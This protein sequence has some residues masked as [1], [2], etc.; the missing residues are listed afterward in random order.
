MADPSS[1]LSQ[2]L[3]IRVISPK[4]STD[5]GKESQT[6]SVLYTHP[7]CSRCTDQLPQIYP[8]NISPPPSHILRL[9]RKVP[10]RVSLIT[11]PAFWTIYF[12][13]AM[14]TAVGP[15]II[16]SDLIV[17]RTGHSSEDLN[18][19][20]LASVVEHIRRL[21]SE[22][23][24]RDEQLQAQLDS[25]LQ[26]ERDLAAQDLENHKSI[27]APVRRLPNDVLLRI[28]QISIEAR[29]KLGVKTTL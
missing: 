25:P 13:I 17:L 3:K 11:T 9:N 12:L 7:F 15:H 26:H 1:Q 2:L 10:L 22:I 14:D 21:E 23:V 18:S 16:C 20:T 5:Q 28:F 27:F 24:A 19:E 29:V 4:D 6:L 8:T